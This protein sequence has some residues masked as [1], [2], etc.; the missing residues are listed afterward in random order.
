MYKTPNGKR[1]MMHSRG[2][3]MVTRRAR[4]GGWRSPYAG[5]FVVTRSNGS[6]YYQAK[7]AHNVKGTGKAP[8]SCRRK[9]D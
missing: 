5:P 7:K 1:N 8:I 3:E 4:R 2:R 9:K 6:Q